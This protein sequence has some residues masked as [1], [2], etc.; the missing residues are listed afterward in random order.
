MI[1][2][3]VVTEHLPASGLSLLHASGTNWTSNLGKHD[4]VSLRQLVVDLILGTDMK[5][6]FSSLSHFSALFGTSPT[7]A[8]DALQAYHAPGTAPIP[9]HTVLHI[10][11]VEP[12]GDAERLAALQMVLKAADLGHTAAALPVHMNWLGRLEEV[13]HLWLLCKSRVWVL[14]IL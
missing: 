4:F 11:R 7:K 13:G 5:Q 12:R 6:H 8:M 14:D 10:E 3:E 1:W 9:I 2:S